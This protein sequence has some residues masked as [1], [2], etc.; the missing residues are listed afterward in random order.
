LHET[1][2]A[3]KAMLGRLELE[4]TVALDRSGAVAEKYAAFAIPQTVIIDGNGKVARLFIGGGPQYADQLREALEAAAT[5][6]TGQ[7]TSP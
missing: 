7:G 5:T 3:I 2:E 1:P 4:T 6:A